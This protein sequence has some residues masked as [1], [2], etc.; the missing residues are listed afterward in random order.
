MT[1]FEINVAEEG[2]NLFDIAT[3]SH[4]WLENSLTGKIVRK[5]YGTIQPGRD[6]ELNGGTELD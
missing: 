3:K 4:F 5:N 2:I 1:Q 6:H